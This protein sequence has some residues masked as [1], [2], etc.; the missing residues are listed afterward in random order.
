MASFFSHLAGRAAVVLSLYHHHKY[1]IDSTPDL[2]ENPI[3]HVYTYTYPHKKKKK[4]ERRK[5]KKP[6][7]NYR[8]RGPPVSTHTVQLLVKPKGF[9]YQI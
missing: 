9:E 6:F 1:R 3:K 7:R 4:K 5:K 2:L 8:L